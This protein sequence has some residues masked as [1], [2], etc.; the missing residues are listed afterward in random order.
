MKTEIT[1]FVP[2]ITFSCSV[3]G[4]R[5][6]RDHL[7]FA[8]DGSHCSFCGAPQGHPA[9]TGPSSGS[10]SLDVG[11]ALHDARVT[12]GETLAQAAGF[13]RIRPAYLR[14]LELD[15][16]SAFEP[17]P[18]MTYA[19]YFLRDYAE[20]LGIDPDPLVER[21]DTEVLAPVVAPIEHRP[22]F[23]RA[24]HPRRW[25]VG[26]LGILLA[27]LLGGALLTQRAAT[28][29]FATS[30]PVTVRPGRH[31]AMRPIDPRGTDLSTLAAVHSIW[32]TVRTTDAP[33]WVRATVDGTI[34]AEE[35]LPPGALR[36]WRADRTFDLRLGNAGGVIVMVDGRR[37]PTAANG[38]LMELAFALRNGVVVRL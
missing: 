37:I 33:S 6:D 12:R 7:E 32:V 17:F 36:R 13:T 31:V 4:A 14:A 34:A 26:A 8:P 35:T 27:M 18:G 38:S 21:F 1:P 23:R 11:D 20:H 10:D 16:A 5:L 22:V 15:D 3:C 28:P 25:T 19:R 9:V 29:R 24:P 30:P 2:T